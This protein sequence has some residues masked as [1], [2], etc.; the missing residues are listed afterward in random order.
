METEQALL[1]WQTRYGGNPPLGFVL[2]LAYELVWTRIHYLPDSV[3][4]ATNAR[5]E[6]TAVARLGEVADELFRDREVM[7]IA[8]HLDP[9][10]EEI[11]ILGPMGATA[12]SPANGWA[13]AL[14]D[15]FVHPGSAE[16]AALMLRWRHGKLDPLWLAV[17]RDRIGRVAV[18]CPATGDAFCPYDGGADFFVWKNAERLRLRDRFRDWLPATGAPGSLAPE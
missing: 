13:E 1:A 9:R 18:F 8:L 3:R 4:P 7:V 5:D 17:A 15:H 11:G 16:F 12:V 10:D 14:D 6:E 2:R